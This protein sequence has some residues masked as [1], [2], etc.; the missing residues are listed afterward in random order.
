MEGGGAHF[1][2]SACGYPVVQFAEKTVLSHWIILAPLSKINRLGKCEGLFLGLSALFHR[3][4][5]SVLS[6][7]CTLSCTHSCVVSLTSPPTLFFSRTI[8]A[9][10]SR[11]ISTWIFRL[12]VNFCG[13]VGGR[14]DSDG[15]WVGSVPQFGDC[16]HL[17]NVEFLDSWAQGAFLF[18]QAVFTVA[19]TLLWICAPLPASHC[20]LPLQEADSAPEGLGPQPQVLSGRT[21]WVG[22]RSPLLV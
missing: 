13:T 16:C 12:L 21:R 4:H 2:S 6:P 11:C 20:R 5:M 14:R 19:C 22:G 10:L 15:N 1:Y 3:M 17:N 18:I 7:Q 8:S 9:V